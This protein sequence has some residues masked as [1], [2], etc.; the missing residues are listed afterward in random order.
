MDVVTE[1]GALSQTCLD[2]GPRDKY[3]LMFLLSSISFAPDAA[4]E[5]I[6]TLI[7]FAVLSDFKV[8]ELQPPPYPSYTQFKYNEVPDVN[9]FV[10]I[11]KDT[12]APYISSEQVSS[13][14]VGQLVF[15]RL[16]HEKAAIA[17]LEDFSQSILDQW[18]KQLQI[19]LLTDPPPHLLDRAEALNLIMDE[20]T[21]LMRNFHFSKY[22]DKV[23][24]VLHR[25]SVG[26]QI[27]PLPQGDSTDSL[28]LQPIVTRPR[29]YPMRSRG[30]EMPTLSDL[31]KKPMPHMTNPQ[32][33]LAIN[34]TIYPGNPST[35]LQT[36]PNGLTRITSPPA[37]Q[38][39]GSLGPTS[40]QNAFQAPT[41]IKELKNIVSAYKS[42]A[43]SVQR[44]YGA[45]LEDSI[46]K[47]VERMAA[48][49][50]AQVLYD[51]M[52]L[53]SQRFAAKAGFHEALEHIR[54]G[55]N[56]GDNRAKWLRHAGWPRITPVTLLTE[57]RST[58]DVQFGEGMKEGLVALAL[59]TTKY[60]RFLRIQDAAG[61]H[62]QQQL[63]DERSNPG[64]ENWNPMEH[65]D[66]LLLEIDSNLLLRP[67]QIEVSLATIAPESGEN[68]VLQ[69]LMGKGKTSCI[70]RKFNPFS[71]LH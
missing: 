1:W 28:S 16:T 10:A 60:Q 12:K 57:L 68:S 17:C 48:P 30:G 71:Q 42:S 41:H 51:P 34:S 40:L 5:L 59:I 22:L 36:F 24:L 70:M 63:N 53:D 52:Q 19:E 11:M 13:R 66:W 49:E 26:S 18:P 31:L 6:R 38:S 55:L 65:I 67:E 23:Q 8:Q 4:M 46:T 35:V 15:A 61:A 27:N 58:S 45:E 14:Q 2:S 9:R 44:R 32:R 33:P 29:I 69:L 64:H 21:R 7:A 25:Y 56:Q 37:R 20:Y 50:K 39:K 47:L 43:S 62:K 3:R 54:V